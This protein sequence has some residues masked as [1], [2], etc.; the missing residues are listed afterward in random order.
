MSDTNPAVQMSEAFSLVLKPSKTKTW[1]TS[2]S[3]RTNMILQ[4]RV[5]NKKWIWRLYD[6]LRE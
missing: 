1:K 6:A 2:F 5:D 4:S 3:S